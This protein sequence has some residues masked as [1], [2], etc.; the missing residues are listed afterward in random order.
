M[1]IKNRLVSLIYKIV[2]AASSLI[3]TL[4]IVVSSG[5]FNW[6][7]FKF[8]TIQSNVLCFVFF[9]AEAV[10]TAAAIK[11][12]GTHGAATLAPHLKGAVM[13]A[14]TVTLLVY[15]L[16][17]AP[18]PFS[19]NAGSV[20]GLL[21]HLFTPLLV[22]LDWVLFDEKGRFNVYDPPRWAVIPLCYVVFAMVAAPLG[23]TYLQGSR[24]PYFFLDVDAIGAGGVALYVAGITVVFEIL[25]YLV[26][27]LDKW[28]G[29]WSK[30]S[31][32]ETR[33]P[34]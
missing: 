11:K 4:V 28:L 1:F 34:G 17:L 32:S 23:L 21:V 33:T 13:I 31:V 9:V 15:Q 18:T 10:H 5:S 27:G 16:L 8:Y 26:V 29:R 6:G 20:G 24:Y 25:C 12:G 7:L 14:I 3:G 30:A 2:V 19:M 22:I